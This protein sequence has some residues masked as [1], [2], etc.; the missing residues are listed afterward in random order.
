MSKK[1]FEKW[2]NDNNSIAFRT[3]S[4]SLKSSF[5]GLAKS[6]LRIPEK[7]FAIVKFGGEISILSQ[8]TPLP[9]NVDI[10]FVKSTDF[11]LNLNFPRLMSNDSTHIDLIK[12]QISFHISPEE[13]LVNDFLRSFDISETPITTRTI[14]EKIETLV[15]DNLICLVSSK[16]IDEIF[17]NPD[18]KIEAS[19]LI[20]KS[21][22]NKFF[23]SGISFDTV[24]LQE[25][26][27]EE[28]QKLKQQKVEKA[29]Q[30]EIE[31]EYEEKRYRFKSQCE[32]V[33]KWLKSS[34]VTE[35][36]D[37]IKDNKTRENV[38]EWII[39]N[40]FSPDIFDKITDES[41]SVLDTL[42]GIMLQKGK[43]IKEFTTEQRKID[44]V[45]VA[46]GK[47]VLL[48]QKEN[49][50]TLKWSV[51]LKEPVRSV[52]H[53]KIN[54]ELFIIAGGKKSVFLID[55][56]MNIREYKVSHPGDVR[57][58]F[59]SSTF[60]EN[61]L[62]A[63]H[64]EIGL[65]RWLP[66]NELGLPIFSEITKKNETTRAVQNFSNTIFFVSG[67][68]IHFTKPDEDFS[69]CHTIDFE[70]KVNITSLS[71]SGSTLYASTGGENYG[72]IYKLELSNN[73]SLHSTQRLLNKRCEIFSVR[74][75]TISYIPHLLY[76][77]GENKIY[78]MLS[79]EN[80]EIQ[81]NASDYNIHQ[82]DGCEELIFGLD[83]KN[84]S[85][86]FWKTTTPTT[87]AIFERDT[88]GFEKVR[89][90]DIIIS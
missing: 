24:Y 26:S 86:L 21:L 72:E 51:D 69:I 37:N 52:R 55:E 74:P 38:Y 84:F 59:N 25:I 11:I 22:K 50:F 47:K 6:D 40:A 29:K 23:D 36:L 31:R 73:L 61:N 46:C 83:L 76:T 35:I 19:N 66:D 85:L 10:V 81:F 67:K 82:A 18:F 2:K 65:V 20:L 9:D 70:S 30:M 57:G 16:T 75:I 48:F 62:F 32:E 13:Y 14:K 68:N 89:D 56:R 64:S 79:N 42:R 78:A 7:C 43:L 3:N 15:K 53:M 27:S 71:C 4:S 60:I 1:I 5:F 28:F 87:F 8:G 41:E 77:N 88:I 17:Q 63:T 34:S 54:D 44:S 45:V 12:I 90:F 49:D 58:G 39:H 80:F 33:I